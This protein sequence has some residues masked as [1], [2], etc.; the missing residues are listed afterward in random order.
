[1]D[2]PTVSIYLDKRRMAKNGSHRVRIRVTFKKKS[3]YYDTDI[4]LEE[5]S[6]LRVMSSRKKT[7][8][9]KEIRI[10]LGALKYKAETIIE[11]LPVFTF[12]QFEKKFYRNKEA[13]NTI[14]SG[15]D[16]PHCPIK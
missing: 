6:F 3:K 2:K 10:K 16:I 5:N 8:A 1:M 14:A 13:S 7:D 11:K 12:Q 9:E 15:F 4:I